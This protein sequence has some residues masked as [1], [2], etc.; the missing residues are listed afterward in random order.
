MT[1]PTMNDWIRA[2]GRAPAAAPEEPPPEAPGAPPA[3][4]DAGAGTRSP[5]LRHRHRTVGMND[6]LRDAICGRGGS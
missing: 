5:D 1:K 4:D 6:L 3:L 2:K